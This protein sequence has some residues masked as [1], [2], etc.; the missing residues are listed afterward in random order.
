[1][2][3]RESGMEGGVLPI[4]RKKRVKRPK[5]VN[6]KEFE[7]LREIL[8]GLAVIFPGGSFNRI[9]NAPTFLDKDRTIMRRPSKYSPKGMSD[10]IGVLDGRYCA[11]EVKTP[12]TYRAVQRFYEKVK[13]NLYEYQPKSNFEK[14]AINQIIFIDQKIKCGAI[15]FFSD[16]IQD[17]IK[18]IR[19]KI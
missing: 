3:L 10:I 18:K 19:E 6:R 5:P 8:D 15:A 9:N 11:I 12:T 17:T 14:H 7:I 13:N 1:M 2:K 16:G 4:S